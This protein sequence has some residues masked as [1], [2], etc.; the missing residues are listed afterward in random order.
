MEAA[1]ASR[2]LAKQASNRPRLLGWD[3]EIRGS[4]EVKLYGPT[5]VTVYGTV[6]HIATA[7]DPATRTMR[8]EIDLPNPDEKLLEEC[9]R[10]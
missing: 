1:R 8:I 3:Q 10:R 5:G 4:A 9:M 6:T 7:L 2:R